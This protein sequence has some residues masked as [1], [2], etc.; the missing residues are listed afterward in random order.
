MKLVDVLTDNAANR[1]DIEPVSG[2]TVSADS[3]TIGDELVEAHIGDKQE[4]GYSIYINLNH[5]VSFRVY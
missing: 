5:I 3:W 4:G 2:E 1:M